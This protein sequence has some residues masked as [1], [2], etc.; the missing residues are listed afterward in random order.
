MHV[1][2]DEHTLISDYCSS[3]V[4]SEWHAPHSEIQCEYDCE[5]K[6]SVFHFIHDS[7]EKKM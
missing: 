1:D 3:C 6:T 2:W 4:I 5:R 7:G